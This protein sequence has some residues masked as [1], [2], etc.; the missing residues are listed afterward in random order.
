MKRFKGANL[1]KRLYLINFMGPIGKWFVKLQDC[2]IE[3]ER[4][5]VSYV[6]EDI[7]E[8]SGAAEDGKGTELEED[9]SKWEDGGVRDE[10]KELERDGEVGE[11]DEEVAPFLALEGVVKGLKGL[12]FF[13]C[14]GTPREGEGQRQHVR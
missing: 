10:V 3:H 12:S 7:E 2:E 9:P 8:V 14:A 6:E 5:G 4:E 13:I 1:T 11:G